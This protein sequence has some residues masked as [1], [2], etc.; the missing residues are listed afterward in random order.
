MAWSYFLPFF[1]GILAVMQ[2]GLN[3]QISREWGL[4]GATLTNNF[5]LL[6]CGLAL[7]FTTRFSPESV[8]AF[9]RPKTGLSSF[10]WWYLLPGLCG[11]SLVTG[12]PFTIQR[13]GATRVFVGLIA[14]QL[15]TSL[16]WDA[17][18]ENLPVTGTRVLG[19]L[20]AFGGAVLVSWKG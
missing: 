5:V 9:F 7:F 17:R 15:L 4:A 13:I 6:V 10:S 14:A 18:I 1:L 12:L 11:F 3:R 2:G 20:L 19:A 8:P 16:L